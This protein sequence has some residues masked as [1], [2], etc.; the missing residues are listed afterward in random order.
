ML[1][2]TDN[3]LTHLAGMLDNVEGAPDDA[4]IRLIAQPQGLGLAVDT[5]NDGDNTVDQNGKTVLL[6]DEQISTM[7]DG[8]TLDLQQTEQGAALSI[9]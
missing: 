8:R 5:P 1:T 9:S 3:A 6:L 7:L 4:A 2:V